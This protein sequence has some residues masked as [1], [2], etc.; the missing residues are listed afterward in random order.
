MARVGPEGHK[1]KM[2]DDYLHISQQISSFISLVTSLHK[3]TGIST[4]CVLVVLNF[5]I[6]LSD[7]WLPSSLLYVLC[8]AHW[9]LWLGYPS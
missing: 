9:T 8:Y 7:S 6:L 3:P 2:N 5:Q 4:S 1:K